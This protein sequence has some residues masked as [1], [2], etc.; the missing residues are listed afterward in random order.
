MG[1]DKAQLRSPF[2]EARGQEYEPLGPSGFG[3]HTDYVRADSGRYVFLFNGANV[4]KLEALQ[5]ATSKSLEQQKENYQQKLKRPLFESWTSP[6]DFKLQI[7]KALASPVYTLGVAARPVAT[8]NVDAFLTYK[9]G[10]QEKSYQLL[11]GA[12]TLRP[13]EWQAF[14]P[15]YL[16]YRRAQGE[17]KPQVA[18]AVPMSPMERERLMALLGALLLEQGGAQPSA[19]PGPSMSARSADDDRR[20]EEQRK[21][22]EARESQAAYFY[23]NWYPLYDANHKVWERVRQ[24]RAAEDRNRFLSLSTGDQIR[25]ALLEAVMWEL[26]SAGMGQFAAVGQAGRGLSGRQVVSFTRRNPTAVERAIFQGYERRV[27]G[28]LKEAEKEQLRKALRKYM[29]QAEKDL[30][31]VEAPAAKTVPQLEDKRS[32]LERMASEGR[33]LGPPKTAPKTGRG[34]QAAF[35][36]AAEDLISDH[37]GIPRNTLGKAG[38][39]IPGSGPGG[40]R[41]PEYPVNGP[42]G[43]LAKRGS[44]V[45][46]KASHSGNPRSGLST[47]DRAQIRDYIEYARD[48]RRRAATETDPVLR[49]QMEKAKVELFTDYPKPTRGEFKR[50]ADEGI[51]DW[52]EIPGR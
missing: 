26:A 8:R 31:A 32:N 45:E 3:I 47:R 4:P 50:Y 7:L 15:G 34:N 33:L 46:V 22:L 18:Q 9:S 13:G 6:N 25:L 36:R 16:A 2:A 23:N 10:H 19:Y 30:Q 20:A 39:T 29:P 1:L 24:R 52:K 28:A 37:I 40:V 41:Y 21:E 11:W 43:T 51:L 49:A 14:A 42:N 48:L 35:S 38:D 44:I 5:R 17:A 27:R 12:A